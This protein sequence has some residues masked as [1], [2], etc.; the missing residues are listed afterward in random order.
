ME[1]L[2]RNILKGLNCSTKG[3]F[4]K[5]TDRLLN[6]LA[7]SDRDSKHDILYTPALIRNSM[8]GAIGLLLAEKLSNKLISFTNVEGNL[9]SEDCGLLSR[10]TISVSF[11][12]FRKSVF[13][14]LKSETKES[15]NKSSNL[16]L[17]WNEK[18]NTLAFYS[19]SESLV[20]WSDSRKLLAKFKNLKTKKVYF[21]G[22]KNSEM[23]VLNELGNIRKIEISNSGHF[24]MN[25]N[26][27]QFYTKLGD[28]I[29][30]RAN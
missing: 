20:K 23:K 1:N 28:F 3:G 29:G 8:G 26:P 5:I 14:E 9:V 27:E 2:F 17:E 10:K 6:E 7:I 12:E 19:S 4:W 16:W 15:N 22:D 11:E 25:D 13:A 21:Y 30:G 24:V 18:S